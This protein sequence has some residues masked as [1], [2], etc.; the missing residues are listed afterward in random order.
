[1]IG[2]R[3]WPLAATWLAFFITLTASPAARAESALLAGISAGASLATTR[4]D[5]PAM[6][7][8]AGAGADLLEERGLAI[9]ARFDASHTRDLSLALGVG[10]FSPGLL[11][12]TGVPLGVLAG[13]ALGL[14]R[15]DR[16]LAGPR[17]ELVLGLWLARARLQLDLTMMFPISRVPRGAP[18]G[19]ELAVGLS[20]YVVPW[21]P[22]AL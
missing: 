10:W 3:A 12:G 22:L 13:G 14:D 21:T 19:A 16:A 15:D 2:V 17:L 9:G 8:R 11:A 18:D 5:D 1:M 6:Y 4:G 20:L 7:F